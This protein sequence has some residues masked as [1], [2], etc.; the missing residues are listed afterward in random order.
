MDNLAVHKSKE[1]MTFYRDQEIDVAFNLPYSPKFNGIES[2]FS[3][4]KALY[5]KKLLK[6]ILKNEPVDTEELV[7]WSINE[8]KKE[9]AIH[10]AYY[11]T[12]QI[13]KEL[14]S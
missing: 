3:I 2:F 11:G 1:M 10:C 8:V 6:S 12:K 13:K 4:V 5:K 14:I 7:E 9:A